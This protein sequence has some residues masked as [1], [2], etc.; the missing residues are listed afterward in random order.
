MQ[1]FKSYSTNDFNQESLTFTEKY[2]TKSKALRLII[3]QCVYYVL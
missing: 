1:F 2:A 3:L